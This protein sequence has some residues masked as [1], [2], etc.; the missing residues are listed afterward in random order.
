VRGIDLKQLTRYLFRHP[1]QAPMLVGAAWRLRAS[2]WWR[3]SPFLPLPDRAYWN[4]RVVTANGSTNRS[5]S[6]DDVVSFAKWSHLQR[7]GR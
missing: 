5:M 7:V 2:K 3:H 1:T 6:V 4:F